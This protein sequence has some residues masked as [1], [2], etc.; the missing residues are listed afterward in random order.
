MATAV[1]EAFE[2]MGARARIQTIQAPSRRRG[3]L[4]N[5]KQSGHWQEFAADAVRIDI[6]R[7]GLGEYFDIRRRS[8]IPVEVSDVVPNDRHL[9]FE[10]AIPAG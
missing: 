4:W 2:Q 10:R 7:D 9:A 8:G 5:G 1:I 3:R 6:L